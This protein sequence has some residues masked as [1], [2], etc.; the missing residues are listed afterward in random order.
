VSYAD[1]GAEIV[2]KCVLLLNY[3]ETLQEV[4]IEK[5]LQSLMTT[6]KRTQTGGEEK[7]KVGSK[8][9]SVMCSVAMLSRMKTIQSLKVMRRYH[10]VSFSLVSHLI[11]LQLVKGL[12]C[13]DPA[14]NLGR[15]LRV[16][17]AEC[18]GSKETF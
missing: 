13:C 2:G 3:K 1:L 12:L 14:N 18:L 11:F 6:I 5:V 8:W 10:A 4:G 7:A 9:C 16:E 15:V 17:L